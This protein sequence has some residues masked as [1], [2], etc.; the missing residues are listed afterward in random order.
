M[1]RPPTPT[2]ATVTAV[3]SSK[4]TQLATL[5]AYGVNQ[6]AGIGTRPAAA[7]QSIPNGT[8]TAITLTVETFDNMGGFAPTSSNLVLGDDGVYLTCAGGVFASN[9]TGVRLLV[10]RQNGVDVP[11][12]SDEVAAFTG[13]CCLNAANLVAG[14]SGDTMTAIVFQNSGGALN[15]DTARLSAVRVSGT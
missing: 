10:V 6:P 1:P 14:A 5:G 13:S 12:I 2:F 8:N 4:L 7:T 9:A 3:P 11:G 15:L